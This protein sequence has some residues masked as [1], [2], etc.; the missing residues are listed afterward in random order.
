MA[1]GPGSEECGSEEQLGPGDIGQFFLHGYANRLPWTAHGPL[2]DGGERPHDCGSELRYPP[3]RVVGN[4]EIEHHPAPA[5]G[6]GRG[7]VGDDLRAL[8]YLRHG[9]R[10]HDRVD[11]GREVEAGRV[12]LYE[13]DIAPAVRL[14]P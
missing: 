10:G 12:G 2:I 9:V 4:L 11:L 14:D 8:G 1:A 5:P 3:R 6:K 13:A 7:A